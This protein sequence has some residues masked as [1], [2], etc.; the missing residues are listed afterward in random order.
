[1][2]IGCDVLRCSFNLQRIHCWDQLVLGVTFSGKS[3]AY[4]R[5]YFTAHSKGRQGGL[6]ISFIKQFSSLG[7]WSTQAFQHG[8]VPGSLAITILMSLPGLPGGLRT[9]PIW[10][11]LLKLLMLLRTL[12]VHGSLE[13]LCHPQ[14][15]RKDPPGTGGSGEPVLGE[16]GGC[17]PQV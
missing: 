2:K 11:S 1:M 14:C 17:I 13:M 5:I 12:K 6:F 15:A 8:S 10:G 16:G 4:P 9:F 7:T 3:E